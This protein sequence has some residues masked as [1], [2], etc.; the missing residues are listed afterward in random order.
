MASFAF[1]D[2]EAIFEAM[3]LPPDQLMLM[4]ALWP[5][6]PWIQIVFWLAVW[7]SL[8]A[9]L[10]VVRPLFNPPFGRGETEG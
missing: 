5:R 9:Y 2:P 7:G 1:N 3:A 8:L 6:E 10:V 4:E